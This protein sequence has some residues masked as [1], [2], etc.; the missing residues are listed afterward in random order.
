MQRVI[1][2]V[3][4]VVHAVNRER[5][6]DEVV[7]ADGEEVEIGREQV[8]RHCRRRH[9]DHAADGDFRI[10]LLA[11]APELGL[12]FVHQREH[13]KQLL[14]AREHRDHQAHPPVGR[15]AQDGAQLRAKQRGVVQAQPH[16]AQAERRIH[17]DRATLAA[18]VHLLVGAEVERADGDRFPG[19]GA[20][21]LHIGTELFLLGR[22]ARAVHEQEFGTVQADALGTGLDR[23]LGVRRQLDVGEQ[24]HCVAVARDRRTR[25]QAVERAPFA[26]DR[27][28]AATIFGHDALVRPDDEHA[29]LAVDDQ[30]LARAHVAR[31]VVHRDDRRNAETAGENRRMRNRAAEAGDEGA[32]AVVLEYDRVRGGEVGG[33]HD[34]TRGH[35]LVLVETGHQ[36]IAQDAFDH[37]VDVH[38]LVAQVGVVH[39]LEDLAQALALDPQ[40]PLG[41]APLALDGVGRRWHEH[42]VVENEQVRVEEARGLGRCV[43]RN[44]VADGAQLPARG[45][46][47][48]V[49]A[50]DLGVGLVARNR[51]FRD[52]R[53]V[54]LEHIGAADGDAVAY[55]GAVECEHGLISG[56]N[57]QTGHPWPAALASVQSATSVAS[58]AAFLPQ[59]ERAIA[60]RAS[61]YS[62]SPKRL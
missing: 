52:F 41:V 14:V 6:L 50:L 16:R 62:S 28:L 47:R 19:Q 26:R 43:G 44:V 22:W 53:Q 42:L 8:G 59:D 25:A 29:A 33:D 27:F 34:L 36:Q 9:L 12:G 45:H 13:A 61:Y 4:G 51:V 54:A 20:H 17:G 18:A 21:H 56:R 49:Q 55:A 32:H 15:G 30:F 1:K 2:I 39:F 38:A 60:S 3:H 11:G 35:F 48:L 40:R 23:G 10:E 37:L 46:D 57:P 5:V 7:G 31:G 24:R 58:R